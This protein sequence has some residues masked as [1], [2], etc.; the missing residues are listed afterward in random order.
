MY[1]IFKFNLK[2]S[3]V[4]MHVY[5]CMCGQLDTYAEFMYI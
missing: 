2:Y 3:C 1:R 4:G 5:S